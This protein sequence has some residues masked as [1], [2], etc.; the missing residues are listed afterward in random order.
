M[1]RGGRRNRSGSRPREARA[2][3]HSSEI[4]RVARL[5]EE[6]LCG[7][8]ENPGEEIPFLLV[9]DGVQDPHNLGACIRTAEGAGVH[10]VVTPRHKASP[11]TETV[12]RISCGGAEFVPVVSVANMARFLK[13]IREEYGVRAVGTADA[14]DQELYDCDL[15]GPLAVVLGAE[16]EGM[17]RLTMENCDDLIRIPMAGEVECLNVSN[18]AAVCLFEA[19]RQR[20]FPDQMGYVE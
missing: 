6:A 7:F 20:Q 15:V 13:R 3:V 2:N 5:D 19:V 12:V 10:A 11:V 4:R 16:G 17:R 8:L 9:L 14:T 1:A 18:A